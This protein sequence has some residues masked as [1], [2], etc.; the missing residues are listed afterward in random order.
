MR[1]KHCLDQGMSKAEICQAVRGERTVDP[2]LGRG[3]A[4]GRRSGGR[5]RGV[6]GAAAGAAQA[7]RWTRTNSW[8]SSTARWTPPVRIVLD[9]NILVSALITGGTPPRPALPGVAARLSR[10]GHVGR[11][12]RGGRRRPGAPAHAE[13]RRPRGG[14][15]DGCRHPPPGN[16]ARRRLPRRSPD[17]KDDAILAAAV[18]GRAALV[19][20]GDKDDMLALVAVPL[21]NIGESRVEFLPG[22]VATAHHHRVDGAGVGDVNE[23]VVPQHDQIG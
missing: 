21:A 11:A 3:G 1:L 23:W 13:I 4:V 9:T 10:A 8:R 14:G 19:V 2:A 20:S 12:D 7:G 22:Q 17:R 15:A 16:R 6:L 18:A 5:A